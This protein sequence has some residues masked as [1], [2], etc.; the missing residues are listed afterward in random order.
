[1]KLDKGLARLSLFSA[2][3][4]YAGMELWEYKTDPHFVYDPLYGA[5]I[6]PL[7]FVVCYFF[8]KFLEE[9]IF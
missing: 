9:N 1:M 5:I 6:I 8:L 7:G 2:V 4:T 3:I